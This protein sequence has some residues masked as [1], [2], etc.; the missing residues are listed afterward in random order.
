MYLAVRDTG[1]GLDKAEIEI[2]LGTH[3]NFSK[4]GT[5]GELGTGLGLELCREMI[6]R[7]DG[8]LTITSEPGRGATFEFSLPAAI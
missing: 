5:D 3:R 2:L 1:V 6:G 7:Y 8:T 4:A